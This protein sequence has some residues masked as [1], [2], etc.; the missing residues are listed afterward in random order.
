MKLFEIIIGDSQNV[1]RID[2]VS[3]MSFAKK[4]SGGYRIKIIM[5]NA[6]QIELNAGDYVVYNKI[7]DSM[8]SLDMNQTMPDDADT[9]IAPDITCTDDV[10]RHIAVLNREI[11]ALLELREQMQ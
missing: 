10:D 11:D 7:K 8:L 4:E 1:I 2:Q 5:C 9:T 3:H 6:Q